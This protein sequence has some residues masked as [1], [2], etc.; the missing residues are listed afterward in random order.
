MSRTPEEWRRNLPIPDVAR[1]GFTALD[2][3]DQDPA[4]DRKQPLRPPANAPNVLIVLVDDMGFG[5]SSAFG[6]PCGMPTAERLAAQGL[7][8]TRFHTTAL[9][10][11]TRQALLT[12]RNHHSVGMGLV[13]EMATAAPGYNGIRPNSAATMAHI[14]KYNGYGTAAFGKMHQTPPWETSL[15]GPFD[16]WPVGDGFEKFYGFL[17]GETNQW[18][19]TLL[20]GT[21]PV[22]PPRRPEEG[23]HLSEDLVDQTI[24]W[25]QAQRALSPD[26]PFFAYLSFGATH[27][28]HHVAPEWREPYRGRFDDGWDAQRERTLAQQKQL[29][30]VP[31]EAELAPWPEEVPHWDRLTD[32]QKQVGAALM[33][34]YA[35]FAAHTDHQ[36]GRLVD[37]LTDMGVLEDTLIFYM[38]GDN[39]ASAEGGLDGTTNELF[40]LNGMVDTVD[41]IMAGLAALGGPESYPH[42][43][44]G[45][46]LA[47]DTPFQWTKQIASHYGGTRNGLIVQWLGGIPRRG[48]VRHQWHHVIDVLPTVLE[49]TGLPEPYSVDGVA[50]RPVEGVSMLYSFAD[51]DAPE[52]HT[53][54][55]FEMF[56]NRGIYHQ[57][58]TAVTRH[59]I[60]WETGAQGM[61]SFDEDVWELYD[62]SA[63]WSQAHDLA[64]EHPD[65]LARLKEQFLVEAAKYQVF[66][67]DD[68]GFERANPEIAGRPDVL[69]GRT[70]MT[71]HAGM[72][73]LQENTV[74]NV[75]NKS[76]TVTAEIEVPGGGADG[77]IVAQGGRFG[78]W[79]LY[80]HEGRPVYCYNYFGKQYVYVRAPEV[81][82]PGPH[83]VRF[84]FA[85]DG[86][87]MGKGGSGL[88][89][90]DGAK[91]AEARIEATVPFAFSA[92]E[93]LDV[94][95]DSASPVSAD[96]GSTGNSFTGAIRY[97]RIDIG[98]DDHSDLESAEHRHHRIMTRQ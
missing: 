30:V 4:F 15:S 53:T 65:R 67:L 85:Y 52:R 81:L 47:M 48:E 75:K 61:R 72:R 5:A 66:P 10:S 13:T 62:T 98:D 91:V 36:V 19:P 6:G 57:G 73:H 97:V 84:E 64:R 77:V 76:H 90:V 21:T 12:G 2:I 60:P 78:G 44:V 51:A 96:Y 11:P 23:Y 49:I 50:Q 58:W 8:Y 41:D 40:T 20:D 79:S 55:Y 25:I 24:S 69:A 46:A 33:E 88:L 3:R 89:A 26:K 54:Q 83:T 59:R 63:D 94:G 43:P 32:R 70:S 82:A 37:A 95:T 68:R 17:G 92:D 29:G 38:L 86:G 71:L 18:E 22:L 14:L 45:W 87:G 93:T 1:P 27:A 80:L 28:P 42:Y 35:G 7:K 56:G 74:P 39:G 16:R 9:C 31:T 34:N